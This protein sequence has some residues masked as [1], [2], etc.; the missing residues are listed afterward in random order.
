M[1]IRRPTV[2]RPLPDVQGPG[3]R[4]G[5]GRLLASGKLRLLA[6]HQRAL[7]ANDWILLGWIATDNINLIFDGKSRD[8]PVRAGLKSNPLAP[9]RLYAAS[10]RPPSD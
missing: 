3:P 4:G 2:E 9:L 10:Q 7:T 1:C 8:R 6:N 5:K